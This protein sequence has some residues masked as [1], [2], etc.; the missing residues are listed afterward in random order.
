M[1]LSKLSIFGSVGAFTVA[2]FAM[3]AQAAQEGRAPGSL[4]GLLRPNAEGT[5]TGQPLRPVLLDPVG[6][7]SEEDPIAFEE[8][9]RE[10]L[11]SPD[12]DAREAAFDDVARQAS[13][14]GAAETALQSIA[15]DLSDPDLAFTARLA[16]RE[17]RRGN[18]RS[19]RLFS[20]P[21]QGS[22]LDPLEALEHRM[23]EMLENDPFVRNFISADPFAQDPFFRMGP[24][25]P[26]RKRPSLFGAGQ[27]DPFES[28]RQ[29]MEEWRKEIEEGSGFGA[30]TATPGQILT[31][32][33]SVSVERTPDGVRVEITESGSEGAPTTQVF[34]GPSMEALLE[35]HPELK[36][37]VR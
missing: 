16:L 14:G 5:A 17:A 6:A 4:E 24:G 29:R 30:Q 3:V 32:S 21:W 12:L 7:Q 10:R 37:R 25:G 15:T 27:E 33:S 11:L 36:G 19:N 22:G 1:E 20:S 9:F 35:A 8:I 23:Q 26:F 28:L 18:L 31:Q 34:E 2:A 13:G